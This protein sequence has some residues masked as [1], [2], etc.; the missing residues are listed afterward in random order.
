MKGFIFAAALAIITH[1]AYAQADIA[2]G[3]T[4]DNFVDSVQR[5]IVNSP[6]DSLKTMM[7][8]A[9][10]DYYT[11]IRQDS[12]I[13]YFGEGIE[14]ADKINYLKGSYAGYAKLA[15]V[16]NTASNYG[17]S[18][19]M[20]IKSLKIAENLPSDRLESMARSY[21]SMGLVNRRMNNDKIAWEQCLQSIELSKE[22][23]IRAEKMNM[24]P[25][26]NVA[27]VYLKWK[28][29][30][31]ALAFA[32]NSYDIV[33]HYPPRAQAQ[34]S[35]A[36][37][38]V[39]NVYEE[40]GKFQL[41]R[42]YYLDGL[43]SDKRFNVPLLRARLFD[44]F[45]R[46]Y[47]KIALYDSCI[48]YAKKAFELGQ[49][50][51]FGELTT[52]AASLVAQSYELL[53]KPDSALKYTKIFM[54]S[55]DTIFNQSKLIQ[56]QLLN[57]DEGQRQKEIQRAISE[58]QERYTN[59]VRYFALIAT[60]GI[61]L[62]ISLL[63]YRN[64]RN[65]LI[66]N[67]TLEL[68]KKEVDAQK[69]KA[70]NALLELKSMQSQLIHAEK[71]ASLGELTAGVA[72]EIQ[73]PLN[74][75]NNFSEVNK[76]MLEEL[77]TERSKPE[78][79]RN[80]DVE[81]GIINDLIENEEKIN[82]HGKRADAIVKG[83]LQHSRSSSGTK[84]ATDI[85]VL[86]D[87]HL[88]LAFLGAK[89]KD[90]DTDPTIT[91]DFDS[92]ITSIQVVPQDIGKVLL[93]LYNNAFYAVNEK[94]KLEKE[95]YDPRISVST[96]RI[97]DRIQICIRDNGLGIQQKNLDKIFQPFFTTKPTGQGTGLGLSL[98]YDIVKA[99]TGE[100]KVSTKDGDF[101][102]FTVDLPA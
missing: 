45:A 94:K 69:T 78:A 42:K 11:F 19:E 77:K 70:E 21:N 66:A 43:A 34:L 85:N 72:H 5:R 41:A 17:K 7:L 32:K 73:N 40:T 76:E 80:K 22:A 4:S 60:A 6:D 97:G 3:F 96:K 23:G 49:L 88:R 15:F 36:A 59:K 75:V 89:A 56:I 54:A 10:G 13:F 38:T 93:N 63:L 35:V 67:R 39:A 30:D 92:S 55:K 81:E 99:H 12:A 16:L 83:M 37:S 1:F 98:S 82:H 57:F 84:E 18:M 47:K 28:D 61:L 58:A 90:K 68:Q 87:E 52:D 79:E 74:F 9:L 65:K 48:Y 31:S 46:F 86:A 2:S 100:I 95:T 62:L 44:N 51:P 26:M 71:M 50:H 27:L 53:K 91:T 20:A 29:Y 14:L 102:Q 25:F 8:V 33:M 24:G 101:T 64:N